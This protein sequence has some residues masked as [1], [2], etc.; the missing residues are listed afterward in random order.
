MSG[1]S[2]YPVARKAVML[3]WALM[4]S[5]LTPRIIVYRPGPPH[6]LTA[7][8]PDTLRAH[9]EWVKAQGFRGTDVIGRRVDSCAYP[10]AGRRCVRSA[11]PW[12]MQLGFE[13]AATSDWN[14]L[15][16]DTDLYSL[17]RCEIAAADAPADFID[18]LTG[19]RDYLRY[20]PS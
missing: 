10:N 13:S 18:K 15:S 17:P 8:F 4:S 5:A 20:L 11:R 14:R 12:V 7:S 2:T 1:T 9:L 6:D 16:D 19:K 3:A